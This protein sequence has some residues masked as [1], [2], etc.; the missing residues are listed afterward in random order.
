MMPAQSS[1][2]AKAKMPKG[3][4]FAKGQSGNPGGKAKTPEAL[5]L[6]LRGLV[7]EALDQLE[8]ILRAGEDKDR[9]AAAKLVLERTHTWGG[10]HDAD[11]KDPVAMAERVILHAASH[12]DA[13][14]ALA[15]LQAKQPEVWA[16]KMGG[17][18]E[19]QSDGM[20]DVVDWAP[21]IK[22]AT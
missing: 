7:P 5:R 8:G 19:G 14:A 21:A 17:D 16:R 11:D 9:L 18:A 3:R 10:A 12:G 15:Y 6:R 1:G 13:K 22:T 20:T 4:P 2:N